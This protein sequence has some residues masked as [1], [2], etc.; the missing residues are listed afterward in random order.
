MDKFI[1]P[2]IHD[3]VT[4]IKLQFYLKIEICGRRYTFWEGIAIHNYS[5]ICG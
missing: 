1:P 2:F 3:N 4:N 5:R